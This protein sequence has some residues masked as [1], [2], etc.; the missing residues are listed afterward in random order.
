MGRIYTRKLP[1]AR[2]PI[3]TCALPEPTL[4]PVERRDLGNRT[5]DALTEVNEL[6]PFGDWRPETVLHHC[7]RMKAGGAIG[8]RGSQFKLILGRVFQVRVTSTNRDR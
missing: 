8:Y 5:G 1:T 4:I 2:A 7:E 3:H 6:V